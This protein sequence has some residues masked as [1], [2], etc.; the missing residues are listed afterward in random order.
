MTAPDVGF[1]L[2]SSFHP[3]ELI[4]VARAIE[5]A[6][7]DSVWL[8]EDYFMTGGVAGAAVVLGAT[9][10]LTTGTG[11][12]SA[13]ARHP[14]LAAME[15]ATLASAYP[16]R[17]RL[18]IGSG[19][20]GWLDQQGIAH[21][22]PLSAVRGSIEAIRA[23][24]AGEELSGEYGGFAFHGVRLTF[25]PEQ[26]PPIYLGATGPKMTALAGEVADGLLLSV[27]SSPEFVRRQ[28]KVAGDGTTIST[29]A[30]LSLD[31]SAHTA[32]DR[33]RPV[34]AAYLA[35][36]E[37]TVMTDAI[38]I[39]EELRELARGGAESLAKSMPDSWVDQLAVCGDLD[40]CLARIHDL[41]AAG[42]AEVALA[43]IA[44]A[45]LPDDIAR[46]GTALRAG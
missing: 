12:V 45:S 23:L 35:D 22:R 24:L 38:G 37:S 40:T 42:S 21:R 34:L 39:T 28:R 11:V 9:E 17:F 4:A 8:A 15:A 19:G 43:P 31:E 7:F 18:G 13:Y 41:G 16:G 25:T 6:G 32:R 33:A 1:V 20:L 2:G 14:A 26:P 3:G 36:G 27:F 5:A 46:L 10:R 44:A 29:F 30:F